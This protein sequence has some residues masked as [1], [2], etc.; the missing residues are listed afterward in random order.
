MTLLTVISGYRA[1]LKDRLAVNTNCLPLDT[2]AFIEAVHFNL[3]KP[4]EIISVLTFATAVLN[5]VFNK[6]IRINLLRKAM[7]MCIPLIEIGMH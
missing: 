3:S 5:D 7:E 1:C 4:E 6:Y 2:L